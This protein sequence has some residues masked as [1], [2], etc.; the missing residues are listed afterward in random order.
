MARHLRLREPRRHWL[1]ISLLLFLLFAA[2]VFQ[3]YTAKRP[4]NLLTSPA[5]DRSAGEPILPAGHPV[6]DLSHADPAGARMPERTIALT[7]EDGPDPLWT[8]RI[9]DVLRKHDAHATFFVV[10]ANVMEHPALTRRIVAEGHEIGSH[11]FTHADFAGLP[12]WRK[13]LELGLTQEALAGTAGVRTGLFRPPY[14]STP[15]R[16]T[17]RAYDAARAA[18]ENGYLTV[19]ADREPSDLSGL[20]SRQVLKQTMPADDQGLVVSFHDAGGDRTAVIAALD[21]MLSDLDDRHFR[22]TT[23]SDGLGIRSANLPAGPAGRI[24]GEALLAARQGGEWALTGLG[25]ALGAASVLT[26]GRM[27]IL[28]YYARRHAIRARRERARKLKARARALKAEARAVNAHARAVGSGRRGRLARGRV[29]RARDR[30]RDLAVE[31]APYAPPVT[32]IVPA[33]NEAAGIAATVYSLV[34]T[35]YAGWLEVIVV[36]DGSTDG[37][38]DIVEELGI[39]GVRLIR[40]R[41]SGKSAALNTGM[42]YARSEILILVDGDT[43]FGPRTI[44]RLVTPFSDPDVGAVSGNTKVGNAKGLLGL[45]QHIEYV[46]GFNV[47]RRMFDMLECMPT[48]PGAVGAFRRHAIAGV[49]GVSEDTLAEDTDLTMA[50]CRAGWRVVYEERARAWTEAPSSVRQLWKQRYRWCYGT[51]QAMWK[52]RRA[53]VQRGPAG[54]FGRRGLTYLALFQY[55]LPLLAP[56]VDV[57][58]LYSLAFGDAGRMLWVWLAFVVGQALI[59]AYALRLDRESLSPLWTIPLQQLFYRQFMYVVVI[60]SVVTA[61]VGTPLRWHQIRREGTFAAAA[62]PQRVSAA[63][64]RPPW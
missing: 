4:A 15:Q 2:L 56:A 20:T 23:V 43:V 1:L 26:I 18:G 37:T 64:G 63:A 32:V 61:V 31:A 60:Q 30:A 3:G 6:V 9:L 35:R 5:H 48:V 34:D 22:A 45:W 11:G 52:H 50:I 19:L 51:L 46:I 49:G 25:A 38:A 54:V 47:D 58:A 14:S 42:A 53:V 10:G 62:P 13:R 33:Y 21:R 24:G 57:L 12:G 39:P 8:P 40:Q 55:L 36:D 7:F 44:E 41:N 28:L 27:L 59:A 29:A 17:G 16:L